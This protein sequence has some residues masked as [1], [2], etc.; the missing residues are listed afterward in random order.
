MSH[1]DVRFPVFW[2]APVTSSKPEDV[3]AS[4]SLEMS[5]GVTAEPL[6]AS[7]ASEQRIHQYVNRPQGEMDMMVGFFLMNGVCI[8]FFL[9]FGLCVI[10]SCLRR[11]PS[12][13]PQRKPAD[14]EALTPE[15]GPVKPTFKS[16]ISQAMRANK[17]SDPNPLN[18]DADIKKNTAVLQEDGQQAQVTLHVNSSASLPS[19]GRRKSSVDSQRSRRSSRCRETSFAEDSGVIIR[20]NLLGPLSFDDLHYM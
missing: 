5:E 17:E 2:R 18:G 3:V 8:C 20:H 4:T 19:G 9:L 12:F 6:P 10:F 13:F 7:A 14:L 15:V 11:R 16:I 1:D